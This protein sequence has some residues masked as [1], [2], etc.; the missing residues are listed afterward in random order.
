VIA[1]VESLPLCTAWLPDG[2]LLIVSSP[3]GRLLRREPDGA[4]VTRAELGTSDWNDIVVDGRG[5]AYVNRAGF[6][7]MAG[8]EFAPGFVHLVTPENPLPRPRRRLLPQPRQPPSHRPT[9]TTRLPGHPRTPGSM[10]S[11]AHV[12]FESTRDILTEAPGRRLSIAA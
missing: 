9:R 10:T 11:A 6:S 5:N 1:H 7:P 3:D 2:R 4:L 12:I 8:E